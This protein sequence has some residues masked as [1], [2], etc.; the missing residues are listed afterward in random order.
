M[1]KIIEHP[2]FES[3]HPQDILR[4]GWETFGDTMAVVTSFQPTGIATLHM[5]KQITKRMPPILT[6]DTGLLFEETYATIKAVEDY[7]GLYV[8]HATPTLELDEQAVRYG[9]KLWERDPDTCCHWRKVIPLKGALAVYNAWTT[10][11]RRDQSPGRAN[12]P[13]ISWDERTD[14]FRIC[15]FVNW[16]NEMIWTYIHAYN[17]P[18]NPLHDQN[19]PSIGCRTCTQP[20]ANGQY[21]R[22]GRWA[23]YGKTECGIHDLSVSTETEKLNR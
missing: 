1:N 9:D 19:Y 18:Y 12:T 22:E 16:T 8:V 20:V 5:L 23:N 21:S 13:I 2:D 10:G 15:P 11:V 14:T 7:F 4:W 17:L 6:L 3:A